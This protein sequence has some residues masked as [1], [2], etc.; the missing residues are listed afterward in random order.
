MIDIQD[1]LSEVEFKT[2]RSSGS[3]G[4]NVNKVSSKVELRFSIPASIILTEEQK[5]VLLVRLA[6]RLTKN[7]ELVITC[8]A[9]RS[10][11]ANKKK[12]VSRLESILE[13]ALTPVKKRVPTRKTRSSDEERLEKK[14]IRGGKKSTRKKILPEE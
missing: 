3:G 11:L 7:G 8:S 14:R 10:Q 13:K 1:I 2:S 4:Q 9:E 12:A 6:T 5:A